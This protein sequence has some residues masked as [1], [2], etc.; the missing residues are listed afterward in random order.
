MPN[1]HVSGTSILS[2]AQRV[3]VTGGSG[4][5][6][7]HAVT[8]LLASGAEVV[9]VGRNEIP[10]LS[11]PNLLR[12]EGDLLG[13][14]DMARLMAIAQ[15]GTLL[16]LAWETRHGEF[17]HAASNLDW[18]SASLRLIE[19]FAESGGRRI[20]AAGTCIEYDAPSHGPC[21][22]GATPI[23]PAHLYSVAKDAF[24]RVLAAYAKTL[25]ISYAWGRIF[26]V[27][28]PGDGANR[29]IPGAIRAISQGQPF[30]TGPGDRMRDYMDARDCGSAFAHLALGSFAGPINISSGIPLTV[31][32]LM[33]TLGELTGRR[34]L[35]EVGK[36]PP[37]A[38]EPVN[39]WG[40]A[41]PLH[42]AGF[43]PRWTLRDSLKVAVDEWAITTKPSG[44][45]RQ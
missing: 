39:L 38:G 6:G 32:T 27:L 8:S 1:F 36:L 2:S 7:R 21:V 33:N 40:D 18:A 42:H 45:R 16:H 34:D 26:F 11:H 23:E 4:F 30:S 3:L 24:H 25:H 12:V 35:L 10:G 13:N 14:F 41:G 37:R 15:A 44:Q 31:N 5:I 19:R 17:L 20:V 9:A 29:F 28:G 43:L 22:V